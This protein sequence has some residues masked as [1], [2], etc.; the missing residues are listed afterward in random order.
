M[1]ADLSLRDRRAGRA[2][3][4]SPLPRVESGVTELATDESS[5]YYTLSLENVASVS[6]PT[7]L[8]MTWGL[9]EYVTELSQ[10]AKAARTG[11]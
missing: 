10:A 5:F 9:N 2:P 4:G 11:S 8:S 6:P 3:H 1:P 7:A